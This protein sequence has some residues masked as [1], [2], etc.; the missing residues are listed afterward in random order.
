[1]CLSLS[2]VQVQFIAPKSHYP[3]SIWSGWVA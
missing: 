1:M 2:S 3:L